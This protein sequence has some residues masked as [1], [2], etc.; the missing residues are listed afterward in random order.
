MY[1]T[2][3]TGIYEQNFKRKLLE[4]FKKHE[5]STQRYRICFYRKQSRKV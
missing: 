1:R 3:F 4:D 5:N 2:T